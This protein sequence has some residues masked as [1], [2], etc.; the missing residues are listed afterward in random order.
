M[1]IVSRKVDLSNGTSCGAIFGSIPDEIF[2]GTRSVSLGLSRHEVEDRLRDGDA[3]SST[4]GEDFPR[5]SSGPEY[6]MRPQ[7]YDERSVWDP[8][9]NQS[10]CE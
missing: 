10:K 8:T 2:H 7:T 1:S 4:P 6:E 5:G 9:E 3:I